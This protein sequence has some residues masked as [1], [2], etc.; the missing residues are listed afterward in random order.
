MQT[1]EVENRNL[2]MWP[3][4]VVHVVSSG[5]RAT[6]LG[7]V[8]NVTYLWRVYAP[9]IGRSRWLVERVKVVSPNDMRESGERVEVGLAPT[10]S[11]AV[12]AI[13]RDAKHLE[14]AGA[15]KVDG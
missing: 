10:R 9:Q 12:D 7:T 13:W 14:L 5:L 2:R 8:H 11:G 3:T 6:R 1:T 4:K 15:G